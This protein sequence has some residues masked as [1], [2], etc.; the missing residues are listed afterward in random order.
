LA[1]KLLAPAL[2]DGLYAEALV[3]WIAA[4]K[5]A[6]AQELMDNMI[7]SVMKLLEVAHPANVTEMYEARIAAALPLE[8]V[9]RA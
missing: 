2:L 4:R 6:I 1:G 5:V 8:L 3:I 7:T 9:N